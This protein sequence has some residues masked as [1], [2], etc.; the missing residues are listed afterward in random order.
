[1]VRTGKEMNKENY[2][3]TLNNIENSSKIAAWTVFVTT[4]L[5]AYKVGLFKL[6]GDMER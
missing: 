2:E 5:G 4:P 3:K 6:I 1:V